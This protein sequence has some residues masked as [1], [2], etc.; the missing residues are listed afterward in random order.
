VEKNQ[1]WRDLALP[2][3]EGKIP[4]L[5]ELGHHLQ[6]NP[7][8]PERR[9]GQM[10]A[11]QPKARGPQ[12]KIVEHRTGGVSR[13]N[14]DQSTHSG[15][16]TQVAFDLGSFNRAAG[17]SGDGGAAPAALHVKSSAP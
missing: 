12:G 1:G 3:E 7:R 2:Q 15:S 8:P 14:P 17:V 9:L 13:K 5:H 4:K 11:A 6:T 16:R 10:M